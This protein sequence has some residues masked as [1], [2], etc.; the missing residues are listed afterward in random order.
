[1][2]ITRRKDGTKKQEKDGCRW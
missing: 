2:I 1:M